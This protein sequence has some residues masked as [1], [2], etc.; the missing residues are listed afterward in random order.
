MRLKELAFSLILII[1]FMA[2]TMVEGEIGLTQQSYKEICG[3]WTTEEFVSE[4]WPLLDFSWGMSKSS[5]AAMVIDLG[6]EYPILRYIF[7]DGTGLVGI[8]NIRKSGNLYTIKILRPNDKRVYDLNISL[9]SNS[10]II[11]HEMDWWKDIYGNSMFIYY[12]QGKPYHRVGSPQIKYYKPV[13]SSLRLRERPWPDSKVQR[14]LNK[15]ERL[16]ILIHGKKEV[17]LERARGDGKWVKVQIGDVTVDG[18]K[19]NWV[20]V[21]TEKDE[22]GWCFD[23]YLEQMMMER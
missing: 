5:N 14:I 23:A 11:L 10:S 18:V 22:I 16:L 7:P 4:K 8:K 20:K 1:P 9:N 2:T 19:G 13:I 12:G 15:D 6:S 17:E 21:L 3:V